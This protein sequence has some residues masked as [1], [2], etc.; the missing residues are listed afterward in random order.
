MVSAFRENNA[1]HGRDQWVPGQL[2]HPGLL[3][4]C[5]EE[6]SQFRRVSNA[7]GA[8]PFL[9]QERQLILRKW[10][11][12]KDRDRRGLQDAKFASR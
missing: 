9:R 6:T 11:N 12:L 4:L 1:G 7:K 5:N 10:L 3:E 2:C 8:K